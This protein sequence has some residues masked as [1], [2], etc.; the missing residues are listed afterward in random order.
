MRKSQLRAIVTQSS[1]DPTLR[2][3]CSSS[4]WIATL[5]GLAA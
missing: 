5:Q 4:L 3:H 2:V 1:L